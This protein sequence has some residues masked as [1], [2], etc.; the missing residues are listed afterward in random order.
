MV[1][2]RIVIRIYNIKNIEI[3]LIIYLNEGKSV[4]TDRKRTKNKKYCTMSFRSVKRL[5]D[6]LSKLMDSYRVKEEE[7]GFLRDLDRDQ[8]FTFK[9]ASDIY[10]AIMLVKMLIKNHL[11]F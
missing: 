9:K 10:F 4:F 5:Q 2:V 8:K 7:L 1:C 3:K 11:I 6:D